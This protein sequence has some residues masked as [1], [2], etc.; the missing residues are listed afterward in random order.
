MRQILI[1][2]LILLV[3]Q[4]RCGSGYTGP[5]R[6]Q[7][8]MNDLSNKVIQ[9]PGLLPPDYPDH[10][11]S[12]IL[13]WEQYRVIGLGEATHGT[14][15]F[16]QFKERMLRY[17]AGSCGSRLFAFEYSFRKSLKVNDYVLHGKGSV[18]ELF[19]DDLWIQDNSSFRSLVSW[20][21]EFN[22]GREANEK[23]WF[24]GFDS[25]LDAYHL[26]ESL[27]HISAHFPDFAAGSDSLLSLLRDYAPL[28]YR[29]MDKQ[30]YDAISILMKGCR[31]DFREY[32][33]AVPEAASPVD[34]FNAMQLLN[35]MHYSH[36]FLYAMSKGMANPRDG[37]MARNIRAIV[38][39][40]EP[41]KPV[42]VWAHNAHVARNEVYYE[43]GGCS[44]GKWLAHLFG[45][46]YLA[47]GTAFSRGAF[48]A[49][50]SD[51]SGNDTPPLRCEI[52]GSPPPN[53]INHFLSG[54]DYYSYYLNISGLNKNGALYA[55]LDTLRP[56]IGVGDLYLGAPERHFF[57]DRIMNTVEAFDILFYFTDTHALL[58]AGKA[59]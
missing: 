8:I 57:N 39:F 31:K 7:A 34:C 54:T 5:V 2:C 25:Q 51:S 6:E 41:G 1:V 11:L 36:E 32:L 17:L 56:M 22:S 45:E 3:C 10:F 20:M 19:T 49:V 46:E 43:D 33:S 24:I 15:E 42:A 30:Q 27:D 29:G 58:D 13:Q 12:G 16:F 59:D 37:H 47:V 18:D 26:A 9:L 28:K 35:A 50:M 52:S 21:R 44:M 53:S 4:P 14:R 23:I 40:F 38:D 48:T 55:Y